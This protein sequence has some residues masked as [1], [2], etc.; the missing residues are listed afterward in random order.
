MGSSCLKT[1][2]G[3][4]L[5]FKEQELLNDERAGDMFFRDKEYLK[6]ISAYQKLIEKMYI[7]N[8][9]I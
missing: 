1:G 6:A 4:V 5:L 9:D 7:V 2:N 8:Y 3:D